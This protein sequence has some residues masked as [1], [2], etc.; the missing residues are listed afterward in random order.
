MLLFWKFIKKNIQYSC[1]VTLTRPGLD[2]SA[3]MPCCFVKPDQLMRLS[4]PCSVHGLKTLEIMESKWQKSCEISDEFGLIQA[5]KYL[6]KFGIVSRIEVCCLMFRFCYIHSIILIAKN[7][8]CF[9]RNGQ[10]IWHQQS[11]FH[12]STSCDIYWNFWTSFVEILLASIEQNH[13]NIGLNE[14]NRRY[15]ANTRL[16]CFLF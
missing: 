7:L 16:V 12:W 5:D 4:V 3:P 10:I 2:A 13:S 11:L 6:Q 8:E 15:V 9:Q 1:L 14:L